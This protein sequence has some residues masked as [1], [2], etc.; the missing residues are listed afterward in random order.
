MK[1]GNLRVLGTI[2][3]IWQRIYSN[4]LVSV[5]TSVTISGLDGD[6]DEEYLLKHRIVD[7]SATYA[8]HIYLS[9]NA[10]TTNYGD[11]LLSGINATTQ[12]VRTTETGIIIGYS[13]VGTANGK[14]TGETHIYAKSGYVRTTIGN[15]CDEV[16]TTT[17]PRIMVVGGV[18]NDTSTNMT[19][20]IITSLNANGLGVG[21]EISLYRRLS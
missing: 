11:Q 1:T 4:T 6:T 5:A 2:T 16:T 9:F 19:S 12:A 21:T 13:A 3:D 15:Y 8:D 18:W 20:M 14:Y 10:D 17:V 7:D